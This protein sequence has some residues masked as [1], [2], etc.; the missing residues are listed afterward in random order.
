MRAFGRL[1][2]RTVV[3]NSMEVCGVE[4]AVQRWAAQAVPFAVERIKRMNNNRALFFA[5][6]MTLIAAGMGFIIRNSILNDWGTD[7]GF[8]KGQL[9]EITGMGL[10][11]FGLT[12]I[13]CSLFI[14]KIGYKPVMLAAFVLH[15]LSAVVTVAATPLFESSGQDAAYHCLFWG[16][17]LFSLANGLCEAVINPLVATLYPKQKTH[18]L[19][20]LHAGWP[21]GLIL[22]GVFSSL[23]CGRDAVISHLEWEIP[24][25][26]F[27]V[28]TLYYGFV[29]V[30]EKFP[31]S[32]ATA[33]GVNFKTMVLGF[34]SPIF[35]MLLVLHAMVGYVELGTDTWIT[36]IMTNVI[37]GNAILLFIYTSG[38]MFVLRFFAGPI[39]EHIN[40]VGLLCCS[41]ILGCAGLYWL[42]VAEAGLMILGAATVYGV[43]KTFLWPTM[44]GVV[45]ERFPQGGAL[46]MGTIGGVGMLSA[47]LLGGPII[48]YEQDYY[49]SHKLQEI[50]PETHSRYV[51]DEPIPFISDTRG[52]DGT[53]VGALEDKIK[54]GE[55]LSAQ[56]QQD[57]V[58]VKKAK[59]YGG[60]MALRLTALVPLVM[61]IGYFLLVLYFRAKGG[62]KVELLHGRQPDG[63]EFTGGVEGP[64]A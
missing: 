43:G 29:V 57:S 45:G 11:G 37:S 14:D 62:Y 20:I 47:G 24:I 6:F 25:C 23:F 59:I 48:G 44:L 54:K 13:V 32:E 42:S 19:N 58:P 38:I 56:E 49:A 8:T 2:W 22:G 34:A 26:F 35:L 40:P 53:K 28:P 3:A 55:T 7:F 60:R 12:I 4:Y 51:D 27:L 21:G 64:I 5:S 16:S 50:A 41:A 46:M 1:F 18:Y 30:K 63:E 33:A 61:A 10:T 9:G 36:N 31:I 17:F 15:V 39:V 52:L